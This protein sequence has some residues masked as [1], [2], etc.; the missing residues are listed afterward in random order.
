MGIIKEGN[1]KRSGKYQEKRAI[2]REVGNIEIR[3]KY[4]EKR[5]ISREVGNNQDKRQIYNNEEF[6]KC[7]S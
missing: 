1:I 7:Q 4:R 6:V 2:S 5:K 3:G